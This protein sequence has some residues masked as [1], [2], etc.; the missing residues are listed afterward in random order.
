MLTVALLCA[1]LA[2]PEV[3]VE[4]PLWP[5]GVPEAPADLVLPLEPEVGDEADRRVRGLYAPTI[6]VWPAAA[7]EASTPAIVICPGGGYG[8]LAIGKEGHEL[9]RWFAERGVTGVVLKY[10]LPRVEQHVWG[11][12]APLA[13]ARRALE[14]VRERAGEWNIDPARVGI[15]GCSAGGH[16]AA[17]ASTLLGEERPAFS[18]LLYPVVSM[19]A[20]HS[21]GGSRARLLGPAAEDAALR[22]RFSPE[23]QVD[24]QAPPAFVVHSFDDRVVDAA[25]AIDYVR[26]LHLAGVAAEL[27]LYEQGGH[28]YGMRHAELPV[29]AWPN[30]LERWLRARGLSA[31]D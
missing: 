31:A 5:E 9:A 30:A 19:S 25:N 23:L 7:T 8:L 14:L 22:E 20:P 16:L 26:A 24:A 18:V 11:H 12:E 10:R 6:S 29:R 3:P 1:L 27:H 21:H 4:L 17:S 15:L 13:D 28:G 2:R